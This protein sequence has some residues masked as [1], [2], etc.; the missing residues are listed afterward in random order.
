M[1]AEKIGRRCF[2]LE[3]EP[4]FV[5]V[6]IRR[7]QGYASADAILEGDGRTFDEI[8]AERV[9]TREAPSTSPSQAATAHERE[10]GSG[11]EDWIALCSPASSITPEA[12]K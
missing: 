8:A 7:W 5:D 4:A 3:Y 12:S 10:A 9:A 2:G 11:G 6:A 1:A